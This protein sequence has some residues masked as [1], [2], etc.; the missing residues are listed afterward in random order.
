MSSWS[1]Y[2]RSGDP[3]KAK[4][5]IQCMKWAG[6]A[7]LILDACKRCANEQTQCKKNKNRLLGQQIER[8]QKHSWQAKCLWIASIDFLST[9]NKT[10]EFWFISLCVCITPQQKNVSFLSLSTAST[11]NN[12]HEFD[13]LL[14]TNFYWCCCCVTPEYK[15]INRTCKFN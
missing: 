8:Q 2:S 6:H 12:Y 4:H 1:R 10:R 9:H 14:N 15:S 3:T 7:Q 11:N 5:H 13:S